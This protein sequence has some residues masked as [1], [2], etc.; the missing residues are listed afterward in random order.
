MRNIIFNEILIPSLK[1]LYQQDY[2]NI[3]LGVSERNICA[4]LAHHMENIMREYDRRNN[5]DI[6]QKYFVDVE[7]NRMGNGD[8]KRY[9][10]NAHDAQTIVSDLL[11]QSR[12][13]ERNYLAVELKKKG[14]KKKRDKDRERLESLVNTEGREDCVHDTLLGAFIV[15]SPDEVDIELFY[16]DYNR[17]ENRNCHLYFRNPY[18][19]EAYWVGENNSLAQIDI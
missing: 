15:Y 14:N 12:G 5:S 19:V 3:R 2:D 6:F 17:I 10:N 13:P 11:I 4:R 7:Y 1:M 16:L 18:E 8:I 9:E